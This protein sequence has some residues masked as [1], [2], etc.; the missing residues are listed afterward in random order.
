VYTCI[1]IVV[2]EMSYDVLQYLGSTLVTVLQGTEST[3]ASINQL[4]VCVTYYC[5][6]W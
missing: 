6:L 5:K 3:K 2:S 1:A 4:K